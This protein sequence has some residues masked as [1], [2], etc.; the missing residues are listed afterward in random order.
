[1][2][3]NPKLETHTQQAPYELQTN[4]QI[5]LLQPTLRNYQRTNI[6]QKQLLQYKQETDDSEFI[7]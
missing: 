4:S 6:K 1:Q 7:R 2:G 5:N 3:E